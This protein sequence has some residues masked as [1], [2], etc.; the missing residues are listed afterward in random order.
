MNDSINRRD[1]LKRTGAAGIGLGIAGYFGSSQNTR[2][3]AG[4][5]EGRKLGPKD[6]ITAAVIGTNGR[7]LAHVACLTSLAGVEI[8]HICDV[9]DRAV[10][11]GIKETAKKQ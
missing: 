6:K 7:G 10:A 1:F 2:A 9:D 8:T 3:Q 4:A 11:K 5:M